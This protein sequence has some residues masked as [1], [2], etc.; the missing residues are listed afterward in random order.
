MQASISAMLATYPLSSCVSLPSGVRRG[1][2]SSIKVT[3]QS[4]NF[5]RRLLSGPQQQVGR[6]F[7][8]YC[9]ENEGE[10]AGDV[11]Q[12][13]KEQ[14]ET[15]KRQVL[16][17][18]MRH[19]KDALHVDTCALALELR[20][21][22]PCLRRAGGLYRCNRKLFEPKVRSRRRPSVGWG[23]PVRG[24]VRAAQDAL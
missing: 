20:Q 16:A 8:V 4:A 2:L 11:L 22:W 21:A 19:R 17:Y 6:A 13:I 3:P 1:A 9:A 14:K 23:P 7:R 18:R 12:E 15:P 24:C 5:R 10:S